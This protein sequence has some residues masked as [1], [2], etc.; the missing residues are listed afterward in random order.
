MGRLYA[1]MCYN[2]CVLELAYWRMALAMPNASYFYIADAG[3]PI[4]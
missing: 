2:A 1:Q 4:V 3:Y